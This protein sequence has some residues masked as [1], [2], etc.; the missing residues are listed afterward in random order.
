MRFASLA[1]GNNSLV[2][3][4]YDV[5][6]HELLKVMWIITFTL[7][8]NHL[9]SLTS[10]LYTVC[11]S[12]TAWYHG[13][14]WNSVFFPDAESSC[15]QSHSHLAPSDLAVQLSHCFRAF[16]NLLQWDKVLPM[17]TVYI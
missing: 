11:E 2:Y 3:F 1:L 15:A 16:T 4:L 7:E 13:S 5:H 10:F 14:A 8:F 17:E 6:V 12:S 9:T